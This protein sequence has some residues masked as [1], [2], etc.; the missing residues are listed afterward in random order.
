VVASDS[1][2]CGGCGLACPTGSS[3]QGGACALADGGPGQCATCPAGTACTLGECVPIACPSSSGFCFLGNGNV[4]GLCCGDSCVDPGQDPG[5]CGGCGI[6]CGSGVCFGAH[7]LPSGTGCGQVG[8][9][10]SGQAC[11]GGQCLQSGCGAFAITAWCASPSGSPG[12]CCGE[13]C[14][15]I[16]NDPANCGG[17]N[18]SCPAGQTCVEGLCSGTTAPC[19][20]GHTN[21]ACD[22]PDGGPNGLCC[23]GGGCID[24]T[25][26]SKN[27]GFCGHACTGVQTCVAGRCK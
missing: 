4:A 25:S 26:D 2:N 18:V 3:C 7:C 10:P 8:G 27:C 6:A 20:A 23:P 24:V 13:A 9:C 16:A 14:A 12:V 11:S 5:N 22:L 19:G 21:E 15:D 1:A 17:C